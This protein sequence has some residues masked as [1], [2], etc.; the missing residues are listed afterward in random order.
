MVVGMGE[1][2]VSND[3]IEDHNELTARIEEDGYLFFKKLQNPD[4]LWQ[5]RLEMLTVI[6]DGGWLQPGSVLADGVADPTKKCTEGDS[7]YTDVYHEVYKLQAFHEAAHNETVLSQIEMIIGSPVLAHPQKIAR[8]WFP[9]FTDHTTPAHQDFVHFQGSY[10]TYTCWTPVGD[11]PVELGGL[12]VLRGS[13]KQS[14][15]LD[16]HFSLGAGALAVDETQKEGE[17]LTTNYEIGDS[18]IFHS[19]T[20]H[21]ALPN[22]TPDRLRVSL[23]NRYQSQNDPIA[24]YQ[25]LPHLHNKNPLSWQ[26][27]YED[28]TSTSLQ[29]YWEDSD[30]P[31]LKQDLSYAERGFTEALTLAANGDWQAQLY[32]ERTIKR[33][34]DSVQAKEA[35][36]ALEGQK[37]PRE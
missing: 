14:R 37:H 21:Q 12:A 27:V 2:R 17:W 5:L 3:A 34:P 9:Q 13:H 24:E 6:R 19:L 29:Y 25:L 15:V 30:A 28:W 16:H 31:V 10:D 11:C 32:L 8:I 1:F 4:S 35:V 33:D 36:R 26:E 20:L 22:L 23:D 7:E 18:L